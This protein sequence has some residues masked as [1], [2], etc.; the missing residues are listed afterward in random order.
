VHCKHIIFGGPTDNGHAS[1]LRSF[2]EEDVS[3]K[4]RLLK[5]S[6]FAREF[7]SIMPRFKQ[8]DFPEV[9]MDRKMEPA[10][11]HLELGMGMMRP[12]RSPEAS[13]HIKQSPPRPL[14]ELLAARRILPPSAARSGYACAS[15][16]EIDIALITWTYA[17]LAETHVYCD[18]GKIRSRAAETL[19]KPM[20][21]FN[22]REMQHK[23]SFVMKWAT[24]SMIK[25]A[26]PMQY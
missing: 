23:S 6:G 8:S 20:D 19:G 7:N 25:S 17:V 12:H 14:H 21:F 22:E 11:G 18:F 1:F 3:A 2:F 26:T 9:F 13:D 16:D 15:S 24:V 4:V 5:G 10:R